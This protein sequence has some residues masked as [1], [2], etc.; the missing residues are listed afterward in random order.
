MKMLLTTI[1]ILMVLLGFAS[2]DALRS[3]NS[4]KRVSQGKPYEL[5]VVCNQPEWQSPLGDTL[6]SVL[7]GYIPYLNQ[8]ESTFSVV[9]VTEQGYKDLI[10]D[11]RN[12]LE[13]NINPGIAKSSVVVR[14]DVN[15]SP[16]MIMTLQ[17]PSIEA[18]TE[19]VSENRESLV[20]GIQIAERDRAVESAKIYNEAILGE[21]IYAKFGVEMKIPKGYTLRQESDNML[22]ISFEHSLASQGIAIYSYPAEFG[23]N[24]LSE[25][26][27]V[28]A[29]NEFVARIP[30]PSDGSYMTTYTESSQLYRPIRIEGRLWIEMRGFWDVANDFMGGPYVSYS[31]IDEATGNVF[32]I[33][34][35]V[36]SPKYG[37]RN[38]LHAL[39]HLVYN[40]KFEPT[41]SES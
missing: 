6:R 28:E 23:V 17:A 2:C 8:E 14:Y 37:K 36:Y 9:R 19:Y 20:R 27:L 35:Y 11:H 38:Y 7:S 30:G 5:I 15:S 41:T 34:C 16:Q 18:A 13:V 4:S 1:S 25:E 29:R 12:I 26:M 10:A 33:D 39:E 32:T 40:V 24:S 3:V 21:A 22:W 31:T